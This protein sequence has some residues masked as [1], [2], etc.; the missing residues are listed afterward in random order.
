MFYTVAVCWEYR[1]GS[2]PVIITTETQI[3]P[4]A[5][6]KIISSSRIGMRERE[7]DKDYL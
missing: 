3:L 4:F 6:S 7:R 2:M 1:S 5:F